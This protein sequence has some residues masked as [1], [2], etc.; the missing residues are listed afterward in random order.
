MGF[1]KAFIVT[2][3]LL[4]AT[5][6]VWAYMFVNQAITYDYT[7]E[8][9]RYRMN[10]VKLM[11]SLLIDFCKDE[12]REKIMKIV[13]EEYSDHILKEDKGIFFVDSIG[14]K[15]SGDKLSEIV[16]MDEPRS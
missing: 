15:F 5:N 10:E 4:L 13:K 9:Y 12:N 16:F 3:S 2:L 6:L 1:K 14:L 8:E 7:R 11:K